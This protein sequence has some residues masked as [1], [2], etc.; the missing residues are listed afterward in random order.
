MS[1]K[2][3]SHTV[4]FVNILHNG[5]NNARNQKYIGK[6]NCCPRRL[7]ARHECANFTAIISVCRNS[8]IHT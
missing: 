2:N 5:H 8:G 4:I 3:T 6:I 7:A 1:E